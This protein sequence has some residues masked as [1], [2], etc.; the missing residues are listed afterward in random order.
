MDDK[1]FKNFYQKYKGRLLNF[2][3]QRV[4]KPEDAE[5][6]LQDTFLSALDSLPLFRKESSFYTWLCS[7]AKHEIADFYRKQKIKTI[8]FSHFPQL[9]KIV[10]QALSPEAALEGKELEEEIV[11][12]FHSLSEGY[13]RILR[14]KYI[15]GHSYKEI[16]KKL[17]E[18]VKTIESRLFRARK[19]F[20]KAWEGRA[21]ASKSFSFSDSGDLSLLKK[22]SGLDSSSL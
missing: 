8:V 10:S 21:Y 9:G 16:A 18:S 11:R 4:G 20:T 17:K 5:E 7:I 1:D 3:L 22:S 2:I 19:A 14:L 15:E 6:I 13:S 12:C